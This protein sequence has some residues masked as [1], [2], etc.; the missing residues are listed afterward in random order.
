MGFFSNEF[1][2]VVADV[3]YLDAYVAVSPF[4]RS[5]SGSRLSLGCN[6]KDGMKWNT[7]SFSSRSE[8]WK[9]S[10]VR[11]IAVQAM[12]SLLC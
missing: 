3:L 10:L 7:Q 1:G 6:I 8:E 2:V 9:E 11:I 5:D 12:I 4:R